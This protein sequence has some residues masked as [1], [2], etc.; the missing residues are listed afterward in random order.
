MWV[1]FFSPH[2]CEAEVVPSWLQSSPAFCQP[3]TSAELTR[4]SWVTPTLKAFSIW[5]GP[6]Q[7]ENLPNNG[8]ENL[9]L[10]FSVPGSAVF[11]ARPLWWLPGGA[12]PSHRAVVGPSV[13]A[14]CY[15]GLSQCELQEKRHMPGQTHSK[16][17]RSKLLPQNSNS[18]DKVLNT[19]TLAG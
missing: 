18:G 13:P 8:G 17:A 1:F 16:F 3:H 14:L 10:P 2:M 12:S 15:L 4:A 5:E 9:A 19:R 6:S 7:E 11:E